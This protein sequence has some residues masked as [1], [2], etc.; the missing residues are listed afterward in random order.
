[1]KG[2]CWLESSEVT[3][4]L[5]MFLQ[6]YVCKYMFANMFSTEKPTLSCWY[7][8]DSSRWVLI[9]MSVSVFQGFSHFSRFFA[10]FGI[11]KSSHQQHMGHRE[12]ITE[13]PIWPINPFTL[14]AAKTG[15][16]ILIIYFK[17]KHFLE[18]ICKRNL[19]QTPNNNSSSNILWT[20]PSFQSYF[21]KYESSRRYFLEELWVR[22]G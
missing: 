18:N 9:K 1:M 13:C 3:T 22:M 4:L 11:G 21:Q 10:S 7:S 5:Q 6:I 17:P 12:H 19:H 2:K 16:T 15:L 20:F 8:L 14:R